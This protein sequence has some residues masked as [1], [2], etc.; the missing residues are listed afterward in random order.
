ME[1]LEHCKKASAKTVDPASG[2]GD[3]DQTVEIFQ[4][5]WLHIKINTVYRSNS[6]MKQNDIR[7][8][9]IIRY[10]L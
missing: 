8:I 9:S 4:L 10:V 3:P 5:T 6:S 1:H 2:Q 7:D